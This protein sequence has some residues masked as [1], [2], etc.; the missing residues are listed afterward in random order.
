MQDS[1]LLPL[2]ERAEYLGDG[3]DAARTP[4]I[5]RY[6]DLL[7]YAMQRTGWRPEDF[8]VFRCRVD[9]PV[10]YTRIRLTLG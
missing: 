10:L 5:P 3:I 8:R 9:Y 4:L 2:T 6:A 1:D 7:S